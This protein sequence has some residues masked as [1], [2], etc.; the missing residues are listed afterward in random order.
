[1]RL[2]P[3]AVAVEFPRVVIVAPARVFL[4]RMMIVGLVF[5]FAASVAARVVSARITTP[6][7]QLTRAAE[8]I[9]GGHYSQ[10]VAATRRDE[11]GRLATAFNAMA[12]QVEES[13]RDLEN[14]VEQRICELKVAREELDRFFSLA[15]DLL[16]IADERGYLRR[17]NPAWEEVLGWSEAELTSVP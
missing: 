8:A 9:A 14:R 17:I 11:I 13:R 4:R 15:L 12:A 3:W 10:R 5:L 16:C 2:T 6:L 1:I 7:H